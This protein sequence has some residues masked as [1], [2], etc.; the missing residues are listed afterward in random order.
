MSFEK[1]S[2]SPFKLPYSSTY[3]M[4]FKEKVAL[5]LKGL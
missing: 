3:E 5:L 2:S 4:Y 1:S